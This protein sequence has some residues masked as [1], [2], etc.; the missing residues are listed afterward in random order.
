MQTGHM[1]KSDTTQGVG[2]FIRYGDTTWPVGNFTPYR[3]RRPHVEGGRRQVAIVPRAP[4][5]VLWKWLREARP[6]R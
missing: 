6:R 5:R 3:D 2:S 4:F 1:R